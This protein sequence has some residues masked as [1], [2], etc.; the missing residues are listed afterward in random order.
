MD[1]LG[2]DIGGS[3]IKGAVVS[4]ETGQIVSECLLIGTPQ[5]ATPQAVI[6]TT[7]EL[8]RSFDWHGSIG[9][10]FPAVIQGGI[11][12]TATNIDSS[13]I[14]VDAENLL[15][16]ATGCPCSVAN[17][18]DAAGLA[19]MLFG[20]GQGITGTVLVLTLGTGI[21]SSLF[22]RGQL[23]PNL[24]LGS[25][26]MKGMP[27]EHYA[28]AAVR[29]NENLSWEGWANR[30]NEFLSHV[31]RLFSP[32]LIIVGGGVSRQYQKFFPYIETRAKLVPAHFFNQA[33]IIGA[34]CLL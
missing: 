31:V 20:A 21:G 22:C 4:T 15:Q 29:K 25:L 11:V 34:A 26:P 30:L 6:A 8:V 12:K 19:E 7:C 27:V 9:C 10:G 28:S 13:W 3:G 18:A 14:D 5:P 16:R 24:E 23:F 33:G 1:I 17:D 32:E 2:I